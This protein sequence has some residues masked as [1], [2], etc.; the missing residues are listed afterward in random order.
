MA[1][2][3]PGLNEALAKIDN[4]TEQECVRHLDDLYGRNNLRYGA[5]LEEVREE[6]RRQIREDFTDRSDPERDAWISAMAQSAKGR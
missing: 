5:T 2:Y 6:A 1:R 4:A 3:Y